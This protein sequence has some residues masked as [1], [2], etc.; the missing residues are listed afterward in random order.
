MMNI[1]YVINQ[2][3]IGQFKVSALS[4]LANTKNSVQF[5]I[6]QSDLS[7]ANKED[8]LRFLNENHSSAQFYELNDSIFEGLPR[9][10]YDQSYTAYY[11]V[12]IP[13]IL[14][15][16]DRILYLDADIIINKDISELYFLD[17]KEKFLSCVLDEKINKNK[18]DHVLSLNGALNTYFNSG[19]LLFDMT[20]KKEMKNED[21]I[22]AFIQNNTNLIIWHDQDILNGLYHFS[23]N[24][25]D[26]TFNS[27][28]MP[29]RIIDFFLPKR[30]KDVVI[31]Y[32]N[33]KPWHNN[34]IGKYYKLY[35]KYYNQ[36][37]KTENLA[38]LKR[39]NIFSCIKLVLKYVLR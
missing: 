15:T 29:K 12:F 5:H 28:S 36:I 38:F 25:I 32:M 23:V 14:S 16:L 24:Y 9:M 3:Y 30:P 4:L 10:H 22:K 6:L 37:K 18:K 20:Y 31:H 11:K 2:N 34:Y 1:C 33:W 17:T 13:N 39:R 21:Q 8:I 19:V 35:K 27:S 7:E 26:S